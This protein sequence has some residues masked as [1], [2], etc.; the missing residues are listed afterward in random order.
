[1]EALRA[2]GADAIAHDDVFDQNAKDVEW[3][4]PAGE[5]GWIVLTK[6]AKIRRNPYER[7]MVERAAV[8]MFALT[9]QELSGDEMTNIFV[10]ALAGMVKR[11]AAHRPPFV[12]SISRG[13]KFTKLL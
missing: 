9:R 12:F 6:D 7:E 8:R 4:E 5:R 2:A 10:T 13:G 11:N 1:M 3:L